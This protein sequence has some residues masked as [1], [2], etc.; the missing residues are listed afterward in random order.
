M[1]LVT[2]ANGYIGRHVVNTLLDMGQE[3]TA[4]DICLDQVNNKAKLIPLNIFDCKENLMT[5]FN[6][7]STCIHLAWQDGFNHNSHSHMNNLSAHYQFIHNLLENGLNHIAVIG[8]MH[9]IGFWEG[10][11]NEDTP[12]NPLSMYGVSKNALRVSAEKLTNIYNATFQ[13]LRLF[14]IYGDD[15]RNNSV[16]AKIIQMERN[17]EKLFPFTSGKNL[18]DFIEI[19]KLAFQISSVISQKDIN[20]VINCCSGKPISLKDKVEQFLEE[21]NFKIKPEYGKFPDRKYDS[22]GI[23]GNVEKINKIMKGM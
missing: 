14:Y 20:G 6:Y 2:G 15:E 18:Y 7:P 5:T 13:W 1:I 17:G 23:W 12:T 8:T 22:S 16:F 9:E 19:D 4:T 11:I 10:E 21:N 3:V